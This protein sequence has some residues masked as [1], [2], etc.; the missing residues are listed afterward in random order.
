[1]FQKIVNQSQFALF[2]AK[3][4]NLT[5]IQMKK[6]QMAYYYLNNSCEWGI[7]FHIELYAYL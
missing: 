7:N 5:L 2:V 4:K 3:L 1:M 6:N